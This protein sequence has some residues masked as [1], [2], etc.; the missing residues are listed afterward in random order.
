M[1]WCQ[2]A[3]I[4]TLNYV[5]LTS[6]MSLTLRNPREW[7]FVVQISLLIVT[8]LSLTSQNLSF[9]Q[10]I[11]GVNPHPHIAPCFNTWSV[12]FFFFLLFLCHLLNFGACI[13]QPGKAKWSGPHH[14]IKM[15]HFVLFHNVTC[16]TN[17]LVSRIHVNATKLRNITCTLVATGV[18]LW[19]LE[20]AGSYVHIL[21]QLPST[22]ST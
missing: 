16:Y 19:S 1:A 12:I 17:S 5:I 7:M 9:M 13:C 18:I 2:H 10:T 20:C 15:L 22:S 14:I 6:T 21:C 11:Q 3:T 8:F 4:Y